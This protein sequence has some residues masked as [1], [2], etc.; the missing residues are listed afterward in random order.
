MA[1][2]HKWLWVVFPA[3][4]ECRTCSMACTAHWLGIQIR[5]N[6][7]LSP[8]AMWSHK[9]CSTDGKSCWL[10]SLLRCHCKR[11]HSLPRS[12]HW[13]LKTLPPPSSLS[14]TKWLCST[15]SPSDFHHIR[16]ES[17]S[18]EALVQSWESL[19]ST[20]GSC[21]PTGNTVGPGEPSQFGAVLA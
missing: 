11:K 12:E 15:G 1:V 13:L 6:C 14:D 4:A 19:M 17:A 10:G 9:L 16:P 5:L 20:W 8:L 7:Q 18:Q 3:W 2:Y 21:F